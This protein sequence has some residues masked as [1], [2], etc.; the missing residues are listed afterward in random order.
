[1]F[2]VILDLFEKVVPLSVHLALLAF[3]NRKSEI[4]NM[5]IGRLREATQLLNGLVVSRKSNS[6]NQIEYD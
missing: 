1:M 3:N 5:E 6:L 2:F 4:V